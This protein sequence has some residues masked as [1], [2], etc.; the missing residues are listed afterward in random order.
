MIKVLKARTQFLM[1]HVCMLLYVIDVA[2]NAV[3]YSLQVDVTYTSADYQ[4]SVILQQENSAEFIAM[5]ERVCS[6]VSESF[7]D[8]LM[9][10]M[11]NVH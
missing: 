7:S 11:Q 8:G 6:Q 5:Q 10:R 9:F 1:I 3:F 2:G 4:Y